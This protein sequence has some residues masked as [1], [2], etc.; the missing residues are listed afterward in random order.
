M[1]LPAVE[2][3]RRF[4]LHV[5]SGGLVRM[6][7]YG[8]LANRHREEKLRLCRSLIDIPWHCHCPQPQNRRRAAE[9]RENQGRGNA[10]RLV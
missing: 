10:V 4:L 5:L 7:H 9:E 3:I 1:T 8:F 6:R 2:F